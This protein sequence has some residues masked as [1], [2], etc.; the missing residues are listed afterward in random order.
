MVADSGRPISLDEAPDV[1]NH[2]LELAREQLEMDVAFIGQFTGDNEVLRWVVGKDEWRDAAVPLEQ[3]YFHRVARGQLSSVVQ[4]ARR[5][6]R[7]KDLQTTTTA[8]I[9]AYVGVPITFSDG[10][11]FGALCCVSHS[12]DPSLSDRDAKFLQ[13][14]AS[15]VAERLE[16][17]ERARALRLRAVRRIQACLDA[18]GPRMVFQPIVELLSRDVVGFE[19]LAR[20]GQPPCRPPNVTGSMALCE[21]TDQ[22]GCTNRSPEDP[23]YPHFP[24]VPPAPGALF[25]LRDP[26]IRSGLAGVAA[27]GGSFS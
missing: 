25:A 19:G 5:D 22:H 16:E 15:L 1:V 7:V 18:G 17:Q 2:L 12:P 6:E 20:F 24:A 10:Q 27:F 11:V 9:G 23:C 13:F 21:Q 4:D 26:L 8:N 14:L 3:T